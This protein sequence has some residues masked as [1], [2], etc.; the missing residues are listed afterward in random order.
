MVCLSLFFYYWNKKW[1]SF[2]ENCVC[3]KSTCIFKLI[4]F[5][6]IY[7]IFSILSYFHWKQLEWNFKKNNLRTSYETSI[8]DLFS[9]QWIQYIISLMNY[10]FILMFVLFTLHLISPVQFINRFNVD[11]FLIF[12][13]D[14]SFNHTVGKNLHIKV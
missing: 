7:V 4:S 13:L 8:C 11:D 14:V 2:H 6:L 10:L 3:G 5:D 9:F 1:I 12:C